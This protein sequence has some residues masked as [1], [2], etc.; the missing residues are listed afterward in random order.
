MVSPKIQ[1]FETEDVVAFAL[2]D[3]ISELSAMSIAGHGSFSVALSAGTLI[4]TM[5]KLM[6][7]PYVGSIDWS[8]WL[9]LFLDERVVPLDSSDSNF[10]LAYDGFLSK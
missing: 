5:R 2:A 4:N 3:Y 1:I 6:Q 8:K 7:P 10:K 9:I